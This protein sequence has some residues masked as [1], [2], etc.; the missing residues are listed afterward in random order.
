[1]ALHGN[2]AN[3]LLDELMVVSEISLPCCRCA[4]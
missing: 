4:R 2:L 1:M 3:P